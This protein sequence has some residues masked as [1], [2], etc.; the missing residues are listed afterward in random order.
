V[1]ATTQ[2]VGDYLYTT[3]STGARYVT[4]RIGDYTYTTG[5][6]GYRATSQ[7]IGQSNYTTIRSSTLPRVYPP[8]R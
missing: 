3:T 1:T 4:H 7:A 2:R 6:N 8:R 5:P